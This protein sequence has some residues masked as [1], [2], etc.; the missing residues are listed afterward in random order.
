VEPSTN[1]HAAACRHFDLS[2]RVALVTGAGRGVGAAISQ[3]LACHGAAVAVNDISAERAAA[4]VTEIG[5]SGGRAVAAVAD[6]T[7]RLA[8]DTMVEEVADALGPID[9]LVNNAGVP[10]EGLPIQTFADSD[11]SDWLALVNLNLYGVLH[12]SHAVVGQMSAQHW[13]R[14][15]TIISDAGRI[16]E[17]GIA[18]Y[19]AAKAGAA[20]FARSLA[21]EVGPFGVTSNS[22]SLGSIQ[23]VGEALD[24]VTIRRTK[25]Y[26]MR[27]LGTPEDVAPAVLWL[28]SEEAGWVTGQTLSVSGGYV[29]I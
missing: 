28:V 5:D 19:S 1:Q 4:C 7:N 11:P 14:I 9:I 27:R 3:L 16:G 15:V 8:V 20:G 24:E 22:V 6:I 29:T 23:P 17:S 12:C 21:K 2:N 25:R 10:P 18:V 26:P 13:G